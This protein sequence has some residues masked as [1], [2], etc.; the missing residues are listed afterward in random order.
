M[1]FVFQMTREV[2][3]RGP[4]SERPESSEDD[5]FVSLFYFFNNINNNNLVYI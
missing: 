1:S 2:T 5:C 4:L 3:V